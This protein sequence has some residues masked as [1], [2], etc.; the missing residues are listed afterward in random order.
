MDL[1]CKDLGFAT[2]IGREFGVPLDLAGMAAQTF[3]RARAAT[4]AA[5]PGPP[6]W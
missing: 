1:A 3:I 2:E 6:R 5:M 4:M